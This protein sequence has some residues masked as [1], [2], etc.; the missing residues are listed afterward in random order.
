MNDV[1][2]KNKNRVKLLQIKSRGGMWYAR[3]FKDGKSKDISLGTKD[4]HEAQQFEASFSRIFAY[5][6]APFVHNFPNHL[7]ENRNFP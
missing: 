5:I 3:E 1:I 7:R 4:E 6:Y 2:K